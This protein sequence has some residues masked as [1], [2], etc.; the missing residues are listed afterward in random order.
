MNR[1]EMIAAV[2]WLTMAS[3]GLAAAPDVKVEFTDRGELALTLDGQPISQPS[4]TLDPTVRFRD[5]ATTL[6]IWGA[7][8]KTWPV[9]KEDCKPQSTAFDA[10][11]RQLTQTFAWGD[12]VRIY[13][14][15]PEGVDIEV[16]VRNNSPK[17]LAQFD[18]RPFTLK[19]PG[20]T[21]PATSTE[22][23][24]FRQAT[25][26]AK[27][28]TLS[29]PVALPLVGQAGCIDG[30]G[31]DSRAVVATT[32]DTK[33]HLKLSWDTDTWVPPWERQNAAKKHSPAKRRMIRW[34]WRW[35]YAN[36]KR[37]APKR[38]RPGG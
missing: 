10:A 7:D 35:R 9:V 1:K 20:N 19:M 13:R 22:A 37:G 14:V 5:P 16:T 18:Q 21:G 11:K 28:D 23:L 4:K 29:G 6:S 33:Q 17:T 30:R 38:V 31:K 2:A 3:W 36:W 26:A 12:V 25:P 8:D 24:Y 15:V 34:P 27:G 32:P